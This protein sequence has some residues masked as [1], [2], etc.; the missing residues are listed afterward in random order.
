MAPLLAL[1]QA[2]KVDFIRTLRI[3]LGP[4]FIA[5]RE[6]AGPWAWRFKGQ[7]P[8]QRTDLPRQAEHRAHC[9]R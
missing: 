4:R 9:Q 7:V 1:D 6:M 2:S 5:A 8:S 3:V